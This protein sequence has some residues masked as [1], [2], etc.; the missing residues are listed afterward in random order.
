MD[1]TEKTKKNS[2]MSYV[3][4]ETKRKMFEQYVENPV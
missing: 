1:P 2:F 4:G 3:F